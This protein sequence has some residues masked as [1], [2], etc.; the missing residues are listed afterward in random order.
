LLRIGEIISLGNVSK[1][2]VKDK[3]N[4]LGAASFLLGTILSAQSSFPV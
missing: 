4:D 1:G 2:E 3:E